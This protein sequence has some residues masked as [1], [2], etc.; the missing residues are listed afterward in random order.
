[1][2]LPGHHH[3]AAGPAQ[4]PSA[5]SLHMGTTLPPHRTTGGPSRPIS[6]AIGMGRS[7]SQNFVTR[8][9]PVSVFH[10]AISR[11]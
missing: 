7:L 2:G 6:I 5:G 1:M 10:P 11:A 3:Q 4:Y 9:T 8:F